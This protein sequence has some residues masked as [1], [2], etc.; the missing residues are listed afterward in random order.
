MPNK[1]SRIKII[2]YNSK[3]EVLFINEN[4]DEMDEALVVKR[5]MLKKLKRELVKVVFEMDTT[6]DLIG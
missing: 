1:K 6:E 4:C 2:G 5:V 3:N